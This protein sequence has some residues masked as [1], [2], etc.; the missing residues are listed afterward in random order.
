MTARRR[1]ERLEVQANPKTREIICVSDKHEAQEVRTKRQGR[2][3]LVVIT[4]VP[5]L[6]GGNAP[7]RRNQNASSIARIFTPIGLRWCAPQLGGKLEVMR[8]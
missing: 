8:R 5:G 2:D 1:L 4:G 3:C 6:R 7:F